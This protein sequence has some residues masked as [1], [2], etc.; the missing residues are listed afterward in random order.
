MTLSGPWGIPDPKGEAVADSRDEG[1]SPQEILFTVRDLLI[2]GK[3][4]VTPTNQGSPWGGAGPCP[5]GDPSCPGPKK[6]KTRPRNGGKEVIRR[7]DPKNPK[8]E[9]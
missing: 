9:R 7:R 6:P 3:I 5:R 8:H 4:Y 2:E 1:R